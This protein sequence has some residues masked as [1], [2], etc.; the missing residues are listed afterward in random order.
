MALKMISL[1]H[2][3]EDR[4]APGTRR[5]DRRN[6]PTSNGFIYKYLPRPGRP[7]SR[8]HRIPV[9][10]LHLR[11]AL[12]DTVLCNF[13]QSAELKPADVSYERCV[14]NP[15]RHVFAAS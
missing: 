4:S 1:C 6:C 10:N 13:L 3:P 7:C 12:R 8:S 5:D 2:E 9:S 15:R 11:C 14:T